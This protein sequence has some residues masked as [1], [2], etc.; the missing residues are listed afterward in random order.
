[1]DEACNFAWF[2]Q[3][4]KAREIPINLTDLRPYVNV[5]VLARSEF[6]NK[7]AVKRPNGRFEFP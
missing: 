2:N 6:V 4:T 1:M 7:S 3:Q 5:F